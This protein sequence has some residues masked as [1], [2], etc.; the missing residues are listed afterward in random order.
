[1]CSILNFEAGELGVKSLLRISGRFIFCELVG[2]KCVRQML[3][4]TLITA[5]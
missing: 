4:Y 1:M 5:V 3:F 2:D